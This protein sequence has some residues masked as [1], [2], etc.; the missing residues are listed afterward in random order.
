MKL[1]AEILSL[2]TQSHK[3]CPETKKVIAFVT[4]NVIFLAT[5]VPCTTG[6]AYL[7]V[8]KYLSVQYWTAIA[9]APKSREIGT[10]G[11]KN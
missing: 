5:S 8:N 1:Q 9:K 3:I 6:L 4:K 10:T 7:L 2:S 11:A